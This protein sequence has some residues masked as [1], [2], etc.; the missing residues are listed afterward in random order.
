MIRNRRQSSRL[1]AGQKPVAVKKNRHLFRTCRA[2][3][4]AGRANPHDIARAHG[5]ACAES[6]PF[7]YEYATFLEGGRKILGFCNDLTRRAAIARADDPNFLRPRGFHAQAS[8]FFHSSSV[9]I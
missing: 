5:I 7:S 1:I 2:D 8:E 3:E 4:S 6:A 9:A